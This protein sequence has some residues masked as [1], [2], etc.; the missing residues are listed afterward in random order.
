[1]AGTQRQQVQA[2]GFPW[3]FVTFDSPEKSGRAMKE[4]SLKKE[5]RPPHGIRLWSGTGLDGCSKY[6]I[7]FKLD[8]SHC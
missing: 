7:V 6:Q 3:C 1:M 8:A 2:T 4:T 5:T